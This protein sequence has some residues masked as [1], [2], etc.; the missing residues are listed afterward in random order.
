MLEE[1]TVISSESTAEAPQLVNPQSVR[2]QYV[3]PIIV[4]SSDSIVID[5]S[6]EVTI[7]GSHDRFTITFNA[8]E[9]QTRMDNIIANRG[10]IEIESSGTQP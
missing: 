10:V 3:S 1:T 8:P 9:E 7:R 6:C 5:T 4:N 2:A